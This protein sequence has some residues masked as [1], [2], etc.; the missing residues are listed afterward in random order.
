MIIYDENIEKLLREKKYIYLLRKMKKHDHLKLYKKYYSILEESYFKVMQI[1]YTNNTEY[2][3][4]KYTDTQLFAEISHPYDLDYLYELLTDRK[5]MI[6]ISNIINTN[7]SYTGAEIKLW[8]F[9]QKERN[10]FKKYIKFTPMV[11]RNSDC[12]ISDEKYYFLYGEKSTKG[13]YYD[14]KVLLDTHKK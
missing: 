13:N 3:S 12:V 11:D 2:Y 6:H 7:I 1:Y 4:I 14:C 5:D 10:S 8:F 9:Y